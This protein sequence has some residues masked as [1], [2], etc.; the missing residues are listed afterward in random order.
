[1]LISETMNL[2]HLA[3][4]M[5]TCATIDDAFMLLSILRDNGHIG[6]NISDIGPALWDLYL[7]YAVS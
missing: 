5:G 1:M 6:Q 2:D 7:H 3:E 4:C